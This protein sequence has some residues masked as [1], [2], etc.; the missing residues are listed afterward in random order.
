MGNVEFRFACD[1][2]HSG[3][4]DCAVFDA[5]DCGAGYLGQ[6]RQLGLADAELLSGLPDLQADGFE[7][8]QHDGNASRLGYV[9]Q[10]YLTSILWAA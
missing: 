3:F 10:I 9:Y 4:L 5:N 1:S 7:V 8:Y 6:T 2:F